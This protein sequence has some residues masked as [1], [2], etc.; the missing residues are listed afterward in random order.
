M[1]LPW[2][3]APPPAASATAYFLERRCVDARRLAAPDGTILGWLA[4]PA[5]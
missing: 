1:R 2:P 5:C 4:Y 3:G